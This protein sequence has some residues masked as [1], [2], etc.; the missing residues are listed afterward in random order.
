MKRKG[1]LNLRLSGLVLAIIVGSTTMVGIMNGTG[2][3]ANTFGDKDINSSETDVI[4]E[5]RKI[6]ESLNTGKDRV[7]N[8]GSGIK[9]GFFGIT[10]I[11]NGIEAMF[12]S[13]PVANALIGATASILGAPTWLVTQQNAIIIGVVVFTVIA[14]YRGIDP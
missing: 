4:Q 5:Q 3:I 2:G 12:K 9:E 10:Q 14:L 6:S 7:S 1:R 13:V 11:W 8:T